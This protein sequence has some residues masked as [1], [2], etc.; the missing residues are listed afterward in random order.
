MEI[1]VE[2]VRLFEAGDWDEFGARFTDDAELHPP[3]GWPEAGPFFGRA[4]IVREFRRIQEV[5]GANRVAIT[6]PTGRNGRMVVRL[7]WSGEGGSS[8]LPVEMTVFVA[9]SLDDHRISAYRGYWDRAKALEAAG[10]RE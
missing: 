6:D 3:E 7:D 4:A 1:I 2:A 5:W 9:V 8:G 10:L